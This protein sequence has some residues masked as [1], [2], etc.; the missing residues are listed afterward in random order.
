MLPNHSQHD[1]FLP[2][3]NWLQFVHVFCLSLD[4]QSAL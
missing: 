2:F 4:V 1:I 3:L